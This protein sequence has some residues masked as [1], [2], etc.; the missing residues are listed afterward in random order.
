[1]DADIF[2]LCDGAYNYNGKLTIVGSYEQIVIR[3]YPQLFKSSLAVRIIFTPKDVADES[4][5]VVNYLDYQD[6]VIG[7]SKFKLPKP[8]TEAK[9]FS[10]ALAL[11][12]DLNISA[13]DVLKI[14]MVLND[15]IIKEKEIPIK[16]TDANS[17]K[18]KNE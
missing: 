6:N 10:L 17:D 12:Q 9:H 13:G 18:N 3:N 11:N 16:V 5:L 7:N 15:N 8:P 14:Q 1:M 2:T 4:I